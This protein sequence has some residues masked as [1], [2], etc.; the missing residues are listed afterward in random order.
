M[1]SSVS[2][3]NG[4]PELLVGEARLLLGDVTSDF[5]DRAERFEAVERTLLEQ[6]AD[7]DDADPVQLASALRE[8]IR[9]GLE[10]NVMSW[11]ASTEW[12]AVGS[13]VLAS[14]AAVAEGT[15]WAVAL[16]ASACRG[17]W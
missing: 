4:Y 7:I 5:L 10:E 6:K 13:A 14:Y 2:Y 17:A 3:E 9:V 1:V 11:A 15:D 8:I 16:R 12:K